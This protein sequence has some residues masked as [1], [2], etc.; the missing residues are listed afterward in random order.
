MTSKP[1]KKST[2]PPKLDFADIAGFR[3]ALGESQTE[4]WNRFGLTQSGG[5]RYETSGRD[6]PVPTKALMILYATG[7]VSEDA[8]KAAMKVARRGSGS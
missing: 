4:F 3:K 2:R 5:S 6:V 1:E 7:A 8:L